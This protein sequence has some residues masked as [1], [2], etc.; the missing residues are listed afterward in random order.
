MISKP[1]RHYA[2]KDLMRTR[3]FANQEELRLELRKRGIDVTQA[4]LSRDLRGLGVNHALSGGKRIYVLQPDL[5]VQGLRPIVG[6]EV[7]SITANETTIV[8]RTLPGGASTIGEYVDLL[9]SPDIIGT[10]AG[11]NTVLI[12][13]AA[14]RKTAQVVAFLKERLIEGR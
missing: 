2:I 1:A 4:T 9:K 3:G 12:I 8:V 7:V 10:V 11:D 14:R 13:P 5:E 6:A